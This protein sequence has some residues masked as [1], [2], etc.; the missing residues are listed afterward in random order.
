[1]ADDRLRHAADRAERFDVRPDPVGQ[2]RLGELAY[3]IRHLLTLERLAAALP[4]AALTLPNEAI[5]LI[6]L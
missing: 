2:D 6:I 5:S 3:N 1:M 4:T